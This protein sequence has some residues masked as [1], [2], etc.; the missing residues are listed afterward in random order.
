MPSIRIVRWA[1]DHEV[2]QS[3]KVG[4]ALSW[5]AVPV[6]QGRGYCRL[7]QRHGAKG[8]GVWVALLELSA[9][10]DRDARGTLVASWEDAASMARLPYEEVAEVLPTL[11]ELGWV[12]SDEVVATKPA[13]DSLAPS[14]LP[15]RSQRATAA[16]VATGRDGTG[17]NRTER[18]R[19]SA[20]GG[21]VPPAAN[22]APPGTA[23]KPQRTRKRSPQDEVARKLARVLGASIRTCTQQVIALREAG[24][25]MDR[26]DAAVGQ[27]IPGMSPWDWT[28]AVAAPR[29]WWQDDADEAR[30]AT[31]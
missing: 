3:R 6:R 22:A 23:A 4:K 27:G 18:K 5:V 20:E 29:H 30:E 13:T 7:V 28:K 8:L 25:E 31:A 2:S 26:I 15:A 11:I 12:E 17:R 14:T 10:Q 24:W 19:G 21:S 1:G 16:V 9:A